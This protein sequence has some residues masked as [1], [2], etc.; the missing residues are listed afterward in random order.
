MTM[1][2]VP[3]TEAAGPLPPGDRAGLKLAAVKEERELVLRAQR[4][5]ASAYE[6]LVRMHQQRVLAVVGGILRRREDAEDVAQQAFAKAY[7]SL[8]RFDLRSAFGTWLYKIAVNECWDYLRKKKVRRLVYESD[9]SEDQLRQMETASESLGHE[10]RPRENAALR[11][12]QRQLVDELLGELG[13]K[14]RLMLVMKE[15]EGFS[16]EEIGEVLGLN[17]NTVKVRLFRA[18]GRLV[19]LH[20]RRHPKRQAGAPPERIASQSR[21]Q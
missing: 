13:E 21:Q 19:E 1:A 5:E 7:F 8:R 6:E 18:R 2:Y 11:F 20:R 3:K 14:D 9:L 17:V 16:V 15:V 12:E 4:G 10:L